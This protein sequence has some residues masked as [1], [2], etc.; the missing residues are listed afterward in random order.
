MDGSWQ[1]TGQWQQLQIARPATRTRVQVQGVSGQ[2]ARRLGPRGSQRLSRGSGWQPKYGHFSQKLLNFWSALNCTDW[3]AKIMCLRRERLRKKKIGKKCCYYYYYDYYIISRFY[4]KILA[5]SKYAWFVSSS[6][7][8][9]S[10]ASW[11]LHY[12]SSWKIRAG[13]SR[14]L[15]SWEKKKNCYP[16]LQYCPLRVPVSNTVWPANSISFFSME[17]IVQMQLTFL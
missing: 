12:N 11:K 4:N 9:F 5:V 10:L 13:I 14:V 8:S 17:K 2:R 6:F 1:D 16:W 15:G 3:R 7:F